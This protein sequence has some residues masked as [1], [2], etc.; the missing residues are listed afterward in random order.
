VVKI[1]TDM[2]KH[3]QENLLDLI[4]EGNVGLVKAIYKFDPKR[5][6]K[7]SYYAAFWIRA[8]ILKFIMENWRLIK[9]GTTQHQRKLF[10]RLVKERDR[11]I[12]QGFSPE[13]RLIAER[14]D[15]KEEEVVEM[16]NRMGSWEVSLDSPV[17]EDSR[18]TRE[19]RIPDEGKDIDERISEHERKLILKK[20]FDKFYNSLSEQEAE[21]FDKRIMADKPLTLQEL[22]DRYRVSRE[23]IRQIQEKIK[24]KGRAWLEKSI[25][26]FE[27]EYSDLV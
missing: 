19:A 3:C 5:G 22:G 17:N 27:Q 12:S 7:F 20:H 15:V 10:Y 14:L 24:Q 4:Q 23:R 25:P 1:A 21:I 2:R 6:I 18:E 9:I 26:N 16:S 8:Y 11:L 13:P